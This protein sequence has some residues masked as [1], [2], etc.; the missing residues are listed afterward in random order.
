MVVAVTTAK[1]ARGQDQDG[2]D[3]ARAHGDLQTR[4]IYI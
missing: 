1:G 2:G 4:T 3:E